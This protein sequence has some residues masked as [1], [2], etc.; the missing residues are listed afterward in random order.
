MSWSCSSTRETHIACRIDDPRDADDHTGGKRQAL[1]P[2]ITGKVV[3]KLNEPGGIVVLQSFCKIARDAR[4]CS[5]RK[6]QTAS[7][8]HCIPCDGSQ[9]ERRSN[10]LPRR[11]QSQSGRASRTTEETL[12]Q[13]SRAKPI[14]QTF[15]L[16]RRAIGVSSGCLTL[17]S[18]LTSQAIQR[19]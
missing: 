2:D 8:L 5:L 19:A 3:Y 15:L 17:Q 1:L 7:A 18:N 14:R 16:V 4:Y 12:I 13:F 6:L 10:P 9:M 11:L